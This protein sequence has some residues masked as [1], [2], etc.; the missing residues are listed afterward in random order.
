MNIN[1]PLKP[2]E[3]KDRHS[4][5]YWMGATAPDTNIRQVQKSAS[6]YTGDEAQA[7][8]LVNLQNF[9]HF[10]FLNSPLAKAVAQVFRLGVIGTGIHLTSEIKRKNST[11]DSESNLVYKLNKKANRQIEEDWERWGRTATV[12]G[13]HSWF[14]VTRK[15]L[16]TI[17][18]SG[19]CFVMFHNVEARNP[20]LGRQLYGQSNKPINFSMSI[21]EGDACDHTYTGSQTEGGDYWEMGIL[22]DKWGVP[23]RYAFK[24]KIN[25]YYETREYDAKQ[26]LHLFMRDSLRPGTRRGYPWI[27]SV[28]HV[29]DMA[30][31][32][33]KVQLKHAE[34][35]ASVSTYVIP[36]VTEDDAQGFDESEYADILEAGNTGGGTRLLPNGSTVVEK[37][38]IPASALEPF[39]TAAEQQI[40]IAVGITYEGL[41][42]D[43]SRSNFSSARMGTIVNAERFGE[44]QTFLINKFIEVV[45]EKW[46]AAY[47][48]TN[49]FKGLP[50]DV[51][52][53]N[54]SWSTRVWPAVEP[55]K[56]MEAAVAK[57]E[58][59][60]AS[61]SSVARDFG[62]NYE[63]ELAQRKLDG[64][65]EALYQ[66]QPPQPAPTPTPTPA[67][68]EAGNND[69]SA[70]NDEDQSE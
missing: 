5:R 54:H 15:V 70:P 67:P 19:E 6:R 1:R 17:I 2:L 32:F 25:G 28:R 33:M 48:L 11:K 30:E 26:V 44:L 16:S 56:A 42:S 39:I 62:Y 7:E 64:D 9:S 41:T 24:V 59:G 53:Y 36:P 13:Q 37:A 8:S 50:D 66:V 29:V 10:L 18:E 38:Q 58:M 49:P 43:F 63:S 45:Y 60:I 69:N 12:D 22:Y 46:V 34:Q 57:V 51:S 27:T 52:F 68:A 14:E 4:P 21:I 31:A 35:S 47:L 61:K 55:N 23:K 40:A 65:L 3:Y 20:L